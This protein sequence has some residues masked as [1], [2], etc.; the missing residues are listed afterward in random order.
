MSRIDDE[1]KQSTLAEYESL[2][3][4]GCEPM[5]LEELRARGA[6][7]GYRLDTDKR[8]TCAVGPYS[9]RSNRRHYAAFGAS[10][11]DTRTGLGFAHVDADRSR[12][13]ELQELRLNA[14]VLHRGRVV[15]T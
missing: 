3:A 15:E 8:K 7:I 11:T 9:N 14:A 10:W 13:P 2:L 12:L 1:L 4:M 6:S 5:T